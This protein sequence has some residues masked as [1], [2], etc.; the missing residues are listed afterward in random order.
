MPTAARTSDEP[1]LA[2]AGLFLERIAA[3]DFARLGIALEADVTL[4]ALLPRAFREWQGR[5]AACEAFAGMLGGLDSYTVLDASV[6]LVGT[7]LQLAWRLQVSGGRLGPEQFVVEQTAYADAGPTGRIQSMSLV[8]SG[9]CKQHPP[10][11]IASQ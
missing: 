5:D 2:A 9:F 6:G 7:R 3:A 1:G 10:I 11:E 4:K 8:C